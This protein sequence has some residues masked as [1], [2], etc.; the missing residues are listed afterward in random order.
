MGYLDILT[1][2]LGQNSKDLRLPTEIRDN[3]LVMNFLK[4]YDYKIVS[5]YGGL[6]AARNYRTC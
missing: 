5:F 3:N 1:E 2:E 4:L 6:G